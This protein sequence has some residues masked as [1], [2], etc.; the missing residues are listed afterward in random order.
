MNELLVF[1]KNSDVDQGEAEQEQGK[2]AEAEHRACLAG[3]NHDST[4]SHGEAHDGEVATQERRAPDTYAG[5]AKKGAQHCAQG[6][7]NTGSE[8]HD[9]DDDEEEAVLLDLR[10]SETLVKTRRGCFYRI[11]R[12]V[13][14]RRGD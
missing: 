14:G 1:A 9:D 12:G 10:R 13:G 2:H 7:A 6:D 4:G 3:D 11:W 5:E 8:R